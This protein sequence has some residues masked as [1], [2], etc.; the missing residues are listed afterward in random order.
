MRKKGVILLCFILIILTSSSILADTNI[1]EKTSID[2]NIG[3]NDNLLNSVKYNLMVNGEN[4]GRTIT[5]NEYS[6][7]VGDFVSLREFVEVMGGNIKWKPDS[8]TRQLG[9]FEFLGTKYKYFSHYSFDEIPDIENSFAINLFMTIEDKDVNILMSNWVESMYTKFTNNTIYIRLKDIRRLLPRMGYLFNV[10]R[11]SQCFNIKSYDFEKEKKFILEEFP[12]EKFG[13]GIYGNEYSGITMDSDTYWLS[14]LFL[15]Q[16]EESENLEAKYYDYID[17]DFKSMY[18]L[19]NNINEFYKGM[20]EAATL[21]YYSD[22]IKINYN[23]NLDAYIVCNKDYKNV[24]ILDTTYKIL[25]V[26]KYDNMILYLK[27]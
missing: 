7:K 13:K 23:K 11:E 20:L 26:R 12:I 22:E 3:E 15:K 18:T 4:T 21:T 8:E 10:D 1:K 17:T 24:D 25:V 5:I 16:A 27:K 14:D 6:S 9:D 2:S 19:K